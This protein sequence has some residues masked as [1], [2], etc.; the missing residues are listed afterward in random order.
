MVSNS[1]ENLKMTYHRM[2]ALK[3]CCLMP[4]FQLL[5]EILVLDK[6]FQSVA[7]I[8]MVSWLFKPRKGGCTSTVRKFFLFWEGGDMD[9]TIR[10]SRLYGA[11]FKNYLE[12]VIVDIF[13][14]SSLDKT[15]SMNLIT[16]IKTRSET[17][18][19]R[20]VHF[21]PLQDSCLRSKSELMTCKV[22]VV[23]VVVVVKLRNKCSE[24]S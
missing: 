2:T 23:V 6:K 19:K 4:N 20:V 10:R 7:Q 3:N 18:E 1:I 16:V 13:E 17:G 12:G 11:K 24:L 5:I 21:Y 9:R 8:W 15:T 14:L 22:V